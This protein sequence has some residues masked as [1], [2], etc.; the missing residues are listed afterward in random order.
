[1]STT[2]V[3]RYTRTNL[4]PPQMVLYQ[5]FHDMPPT[6]VRHVSLA[7]VTEVFMLKTFTDSGEAVRPRGGNYAPLRST[8]QNVFNDT[9]PIV[10]PLQIQLTDGGTPQPSQ[11]SGDDTLPPPRSGQTSPAPP[12]ARAR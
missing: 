10:T 11:Y 3:S 5:T 2:T 1:M 6:T 8:I 7:P 4:T 9:R 12:P